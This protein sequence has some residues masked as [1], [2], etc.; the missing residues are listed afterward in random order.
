ML[1]SAILGVNIAPGV[2]FHDSGEF[3]MA[4]AS[5]GIPHSPGA[6]TWAILASLLVKA[7]PFWEPAYVTNLMSALLGAATLGLTYALVLKWT[8]PYETRIRHMAAVASV[9]VLL[10]CNAFLEQS[11]VTEQYTLLTALLAGILLL[12]THVVDTPSVRGF[13]GLGLLYGLAMGNHPSQLLIGPALVAI[14]WASTGKAKPFFRAFGFGLVGTVAGLMVFLWLPIRS[15]ADPLM[16]WG[17]P[18]NWD[19]FVWTLTRQQWET[20]AIAEAPAGMVPEWFRSYDFLGQIGPVALLLGLAGLVI[21]AVRSRSRF[22]WLAWLIVPYAGILLVGHLRQ[23]KMDT[24]YI[25]HYGVMDWH[26]PVYLAIAVGVGIAVAALVRALPRFGLA[27]GVV[28]LGLGAVQA[29]LQVGNASLRSFS[30]PDRFV[31]A[32][33]APLP[34]DAMI[35]STSDNFCHTIGYAIHLQNALP[36]VWMGYGAIFHGMMSPNGLT[37]DEDRKVAYLSS[38]VFKPGDQPLT[39]PKLPSDE[40]RRRPL[41]GEY[42]SEL[43]TTAQWLRPAGLLFEYRT[44]PVSDAEVRAAEA[45]L[46]QKH[47]EVFALP[48]TNP[49]RLEREAFSVAHQRRG[50]FFLTRNMPDLA[51]PSFE[52]ALRWEPSNGQIWFGY[53]TALEAAGSAKAA[54]TAYETAIRTN[55]WIPGPRESLAILKAQSGDL[56]GAETLLVEEATVS[57]SPSVAHNLGLVRK[58]LGR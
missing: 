40:I 31:K 34:K 16:D 30:A 7:L 19:R 43:P 13:L 33:L 14:A 18:D 42:L 29:A 51:V 24:V 53:G 17:H 46:R 48:G 56:K 15:S 10:G 9:L 11:F 1:A 41:F 57:K 47:P 5:A 52:L 50:L 25:R 27:L 45:S 2:T 4:A 12:G 20:R 23:A 39:L 49:H 36:G 22:G 32:I 8:K 6:P 44:T 54:A 55:R 21:L 58:Q 3:A 28:V 35:V 38:R 26:L 37:W